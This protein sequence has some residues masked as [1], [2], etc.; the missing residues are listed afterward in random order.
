MYQMSWAVNHGDNKIED[1]F[2]FADTFEEVCDWVENIKEQE[3]VHHWA[4][5]MV[6]GSSEPQHEEVH[7]EDEREREMWQENAM[8]ISQQGGY[9]ASD[10]EGRGTQVIRAL[11]IMPRTMNNAELF[12]TMM[13]LLNAY[14]A[15]DDEKRWMLKTCLAS[16]DTMSDLAEK[17]KRMIN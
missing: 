7:P 6:L 15:D 16:V 1:F 2:Q 4:V 17:A 5:S 9:T 13:N 11:S 8:F 3:D 14:I 10:S 12:S